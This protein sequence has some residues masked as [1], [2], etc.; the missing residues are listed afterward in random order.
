M[1]LFLRGSSATLAASMIRSPTALRGLLLVSEN[2]PS[3]RAKM[4]KV[5]NLLPHKIEHKGNIIYALLPLNSSLL[6]PAF[7]SAQTLTRR[8][9]HARIPLK[10]AA[11]RFELQRLVV[12]TLSHQ[13]SAIRS[14]LHIH[15]KVTPHSSFFTQISS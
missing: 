1:S 14:T 12:C 2:S 9:D 3:V 15:L 6:S 13:P 4:L 7:V 10:E 8:R 5:C 11:K